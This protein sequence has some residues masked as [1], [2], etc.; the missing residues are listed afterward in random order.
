MISLKMFPQPHSVSALCKDNPWKSWLQ[1]HQLSGV[2][3][4]EC[5]PPV[6]TVTQPWC[7]TQTHPNST[8][9]SGAGKYGKHGT[10][11]ESIQP[12]KGMAPAHLPAPEGARDQTSR[13]KER[14]AA[15]DPPGQ[16]LVA[17][18]TI[19]PK[20]QIR[21]YPELHL[22]SHWLPHLLSLRSNLR[23]RCTKNLS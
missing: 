13:D 20:C 7:S 19:S 23:D 16:L 15:L 22:L 3:Y 14:L 21:L 10:L 6:A 18:F 12:F 11:E 9:I 2:T 8:H 4:R 5:A 1:S 17:R